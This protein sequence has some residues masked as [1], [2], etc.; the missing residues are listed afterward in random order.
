VAPLDPTCPFGGARFTVGGV[1]TYACDGANGAVG[2]QGEVG[3][4]GATGPAGPAGSAGESVTAQSVGPLDPNCPSG[5]SRFTVGATT[6]YACN[7][8][9][10][11]TGN[12]GPQGPQGLQGIQ[13]LQ[14]PAGVVDYSL[15][16]R[17]DTA[18]QPNSNFNISGTGSVGGD[19]AVGG[20]L[21]V[22]GSVFS[23]AVVTGT[24]QL[25]QW[26]I[27]TIGNGTYQTVWSDTIEL[28]RPSLLFVA[29]NG[30]WNTTYHTYGTVVI[31]GA[32]LAASCDGTVGCYGA[33][34]T[35][36]GAFLSI[37]YS[38]FAQ[39]TGGS[40]TVAFAVVNNAGSCIVAGARIDWAAIPL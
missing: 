20:D 33:A 12:T 21:S 3:P 40:H 37:G 26:G 31:D 15:A 22:T 25:P 17:N 7:G 4:P 2:P 16:I 8:A 11:A 30:H 29:V 18:L 35:D 36:S 24:I 13:G 32:P 28:T 14:G 39:V 5:G 1:T 27:Q 23:G 6:T 9:A 19:L 10:G 34:H 38:S